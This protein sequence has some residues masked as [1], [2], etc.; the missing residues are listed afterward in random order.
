[1]TILDVKD[2]IN[3]AEGY[4]ALRKTVINALEGGAKNDIQIILQ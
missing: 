4:V 1:V 3:I 2:S